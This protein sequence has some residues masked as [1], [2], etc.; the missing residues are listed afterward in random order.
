VSAALREPAVPPE[1]ADDGPSTSA[2]V[3][4]IGATAQR[5]VIGAAADTFLAGLTAAA[6]GAA[7]AAAADQIEAVTGATRHVGAL[8]GLA[9]DSVLASAFAVAFDQAAAGFRAATR[10]SWTAVR[11]GTVN[12]TLSCVTTHVVGAREVSLTADLAR[13]TAAGDWARTAV[14]AGALHITT[15]GS[16]AI[17]AI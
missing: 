17:N 8:G 10:F 15:C 3:A 5:A 14:F 13:V 9:L 12:L 7:G 2:S 16:S 4:L 1:L 11:A 6:D